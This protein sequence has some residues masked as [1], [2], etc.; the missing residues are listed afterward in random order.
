MSDNNLKVIYNE[1][2]KRLESLTK[3]NGFVF[4]IGST[5][6]DAAQHLTVD[7][8]PCAAIVMGEVRSADK[9]T[10][11][12]KCSFVVDVMVNAHCL[13]P[14]LEVGV[15]EKT[16]TEVALDLMFDVQKALLSGGVVLKQNLD[17][18]KIEDVV[19]SI[20]QTKQDGLPVISVGVLLRVVYNQIFK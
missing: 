11:N 6:Y 20:A 17:N 3:A 7:Q 2:K 4:D 5:I 19:S 1:L 12:L 15:P 8:M 16:D 9:V 10:N 18:V 14:E 13:K